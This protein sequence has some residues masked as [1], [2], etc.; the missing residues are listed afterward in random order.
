LQEIF[1]NNGVKAPFLTTVL[2]SMAPN[3]NGK[4]NKEQ[5][6]QKIEYI[7]EENDLSEYKY[8]E[9]HLVELALI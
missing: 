6:I 2:Q 3:S 8:Y 4:Y 7:K 1:K 9:K 5:V